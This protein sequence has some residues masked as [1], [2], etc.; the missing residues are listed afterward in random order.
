M[1]TV[2]GNLSTLTLTLSHWERGWSLPRGNSRFAAGRDALRLLFRE[3][4]ADA[5]GL[6][7]IIDVDAH[8]DVSLAELTL[9][10]LGFILGN[11]QANE[12][13][14]QST[15]RIANLAFGLFAVASLGA[16][17]GSK[18]STDPPA[19]WKVPRTAD[20]KPDLQ[21]NWTNETQT[22]LERM[23]AE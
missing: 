14:G 23:S 1:K 18:Y 16:Q 20:G 17:S 21:G 6:F 7:A 19:G 9:V 10:L 22:P 4:L 2:P 15:D 11:A 8:Q 13:A 12:G 5:S 3:N